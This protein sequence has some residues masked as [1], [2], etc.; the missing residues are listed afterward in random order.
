MKE[1]GNFPCIREKRNTSRVSENLKERDIL[2]DLGVNGTV[3]LKADHKEM[4]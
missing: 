1:A 2:E 4:E 3:M